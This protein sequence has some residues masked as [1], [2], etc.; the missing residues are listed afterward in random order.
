[1]KEDAF[2]ADI[3]KMLLDV[4]MC[5]N[6]SKEIKN[7]LVSIAIQLEVMFQNHKYRGMKALLINYIPMSLLMEEKYTV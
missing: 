5:R 3:D 4:Y 6:R 7:L 1:M 2:L